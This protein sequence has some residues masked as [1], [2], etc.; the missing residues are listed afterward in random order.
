[1]LRAVAESILRTV[2]ESAFKMDAATARSMT[3]P[4]IEKSTNTPY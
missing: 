1:M 2:A 4:K 3:G